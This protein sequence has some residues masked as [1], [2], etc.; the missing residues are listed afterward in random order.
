MKQF[1]YRTGSSS[2]KNL[3]TFNSL[4]LK[5]FI[6]WLR[7]NTILFY[8]E[9][10]LVNLLVRHSD[11]VVI[12]Y[13]TRLYYYIRLGIPIYSIEGGYY[14]C[15]CFI[16]KLRNSDKTISEGVGDII[17]GLKVNKCESTMKL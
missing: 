4:S 17:Y 12:L 1:Y 15:L 2:L 16:K 6:Y 13:D 5:S 8:H 7:N 9:M 10:T 3:N 14:Y 11:Y